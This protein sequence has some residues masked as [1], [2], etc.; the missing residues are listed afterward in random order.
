MTDTKKF[1][2]SN[3]DAERA[4][5]TYL[6]LVT[7]IENRD[8]IGFDKFSSN[9]NDLFLIKGHKISTKLKRKAFREVRDILGNK[10]IE[11]IQAYRDDMYIFK[12]TKVPEDILEL[13]K[14]KNANL[15]ICLAANRD[16]NL[17]GFDVF[18]RYSYRDTL[19]LNRIPFELNESSVKKL[20]KSIPIKS[21]L[22]A[23][24]KE[25]MKL[26]QDNGASI[27]EKRRAVQKYKAP[28]ATQ[29]FRVFMNRFTIY[30]CKEKLLVND[31]VVLCNRVHIMNL[32]NMK[33]IKY[34]FCE[35]S[36]KRKETMKKVKRNI[37]RSKKRKKT[38]K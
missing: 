13:A 27:E 2:L 9:W 26:L 12:G 24:E 11:E 28:F 6:N 31:C 14:K 1:T 35:G 38:K 3:I 21:V 22:V 34:E 7:C 30:E 29:K 19:R 17:S 20:I 8:E 18:I 33:P 37:R 25:L 5:V 32:S 15:N 4:V 36:G 16:K 23:N 10:S